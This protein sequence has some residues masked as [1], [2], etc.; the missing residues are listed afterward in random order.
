MDTIWTVDSRRILRAAWK[1]RWLAASQCESQ[2]PQHTLVAPSSIARTPVRWRGDEAPVAERR[3]ATR[4]AEAAGWRFGVRTQSVRWVRSVRAVHH[5]AWRDP[6]RRASTRSSTDRASTPTRWA[7]VRT[8][9]TAAQPG[10]LME[11]SR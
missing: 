4:S 11:P 7:V 9:P 8:R 6:I 2:R 10:A 1:H 3:W 5:T